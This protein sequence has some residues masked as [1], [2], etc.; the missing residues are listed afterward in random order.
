MLRDLSR[1]V[2]TKVADYTGDVATTE[3]V[4]FVKHDQRNR[5]SETQMDIDEVYLQGSQ[6]CN[7]QIGH[8]IIPLT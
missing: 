6:S 2:R 5:K 3:D 7:P 1:R 8:G 4:A